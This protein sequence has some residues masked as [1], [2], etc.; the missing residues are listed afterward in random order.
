MH[1]IVFVEYLEGI[2]ELLE[3][4]QRLLFRDVFILSQDSFERASVTELVDEVEVIGSLEHIDVFY[5]VF[6]LL[7]I[8]EDVDLVDCALFQ[9]LVLFEPAHLNYL[10]R[11]LFVI[12][13]IY[14]SIHLSIGAFSDYFV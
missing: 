8:G 5:D 4:K 14:C 2:D 7:D 1:N 6:V 10:Y 13:L 3:D 9:F 12:V 11:I